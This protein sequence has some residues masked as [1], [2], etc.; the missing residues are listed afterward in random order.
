[1]IFLILAIGF[2]T[3]TISSIS[4]IRNQEDKDILARVGKGIGDIE[5]QRE[6]CDEFGECINETYIDKLQLQEKGCDSNFCYF[7]L[8]ESGG[9][10]KDIQVNL[11]PVCSKYGMCE[12]LEMGEEYECCLN[13]RDLTEEEILVNASKE[14]NEILNK[15]ISVTL[16]REQRAERNKR[17]EDIEI[18]L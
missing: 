11:N 16:A 18:N 8:Y 3:A 9:I 2:A 7:K 17:F 15:I 6:V 1:M 13:Y 5:K 10:N 14:V 4:L 12:D